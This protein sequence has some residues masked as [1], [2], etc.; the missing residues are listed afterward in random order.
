MVNSVDRDAVADEE[1]DEQEDQN[2]QSDDHLSKNEKR[3]ACLASG[4]SLDISD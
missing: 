2:H 3:K 1:R 4:F